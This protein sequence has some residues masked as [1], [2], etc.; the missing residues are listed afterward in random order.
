M[1]VVQCHANVE[2]AL[3][4]RTESRSIPVYL[5]TLASRSISM[6][7][8]YKT[9]V[10]LFHKDEWE[11]DKALESLAGPLNEFTKRG[12][13]NITILRSGCPSRQANE[14]PSPSM[15]PSPL[16]VYANREHQSL[17][18]SFGDGVA[19]SYVT[20]TK[21]RASKLKLDDAITP[22][23]ETAEDKSSD[24]M[25]FSHAAT[26]PRWSNVHAVCSYH[27]LSNRDQQRSQIYHLG[28]T[29]G[30]R[31]TVCLY[32]AAHTGPDLRR[33]RFGRPR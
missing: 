26:D 5:V 28:G 9:V 13:C 18:T 10:R 23:E 20:L 16:K 14:Y 1:H 12:K 3:A 29:T 11:S 32:C 21:D 27:Q 24:K 25:W 19:L 7:V 22:A 30:L 31:A 33:C 17:S 8:G 4:N 2:L 15:P 6:D